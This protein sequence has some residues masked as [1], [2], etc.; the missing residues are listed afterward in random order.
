M[1][2]QSR[3]KNKEMKKK[4]EESRKIEQ[5]R[6]REKKERKR[7]TE[8]ALA[9]CSSRT[10]ILRSSNSP[11]TVSFSVSSSWLSV[12]HRTSVSCCRRMRCSRIVS[13]V[14]RRLLRTS[15]LSSEQAALKRY[16][17]YFGGKGEKKKRWYFCSRFFRFKC[18]MLPCFLC[19][20]FVSL[21]EW[22]FRGKKK[23][24]FAFMLGL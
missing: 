8:P 9:F 23:G 3:Y 6:R 11:R 20:S 12:C 15:V 22:G 16:V 13:S 4:K 14:A 19:F 5:G 24:G 2:D 21:L 1:R 10:A 7:H 18:F 17:S